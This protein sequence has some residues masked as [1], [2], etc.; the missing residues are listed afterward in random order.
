MALFK[1]QFITYKKGLQLSLSTGYLPV[2]VTPGPPAI[3]HTGTMTFNQLRAPRQHRLSLCCAW[4]NRPQTCPGRP[5][6]VDMGLPAAIILKAI[7]SAHPAPKLA[8]Q[9]RHVACVHA[10]SVPQ[11]RFDASPEAHN[12]CPARRTPFVT[13]E[14]LTHPSRRGTLPSLCTLSPSDLIVFWF[15]SVLFSGLYCHCGAGVVTW[16]PHLPRCGAYLLA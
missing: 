12:P 11:S 16:Q 6:A 9:G 14:V 5:R 1:C 7:I 3:T 15:A 13:S 10:L 4:G 2:F 8:R